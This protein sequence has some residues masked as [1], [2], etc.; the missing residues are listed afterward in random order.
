MIARICGSRSARRRRAGAVCGPREV[1]DRHFAAQRAM[2]DLGVR[3]GRQPLVHRP[4]LVGLQV[5]EPDPPHPFK[6]HHS[7]HRHGHQRKQRAHAAVVEQRLL[8]VDEELVDREAGRRRHVGQVG[9]EPVDA[10]G[11][12]IGPGLHG[13]LRV[14]VRD[15]ASRRATPRGIGGLTHSRGRGPPVKSRCGRLA[16]RAAPGCGN[17]FGSASSRH[18]S[19]RCG[20]TARALPRSPGWTAPRPPASTWSAKRNSAR[21]CRVTYR[22]IR[23]AAST[24]LACDVCATRRARGSYGHYRR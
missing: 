22:S 8:S 7:F 10:V 18:A 15:R 1:V 2:S 12:L 24:Y 21:D 16:R 23:L 4:G 9:G 3:G 11:D 19:R 5:R 13:C 20:V 6:R 14:W 17:R